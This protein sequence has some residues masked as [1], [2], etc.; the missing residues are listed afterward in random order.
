MYWVRTRIRLLVRVCLLV[1][2]LPVVVIELVLSL[3][4]QG[5]PIQSIH[6]Y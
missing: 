6:H 2:V 1:A 3:L 4:H 5:D